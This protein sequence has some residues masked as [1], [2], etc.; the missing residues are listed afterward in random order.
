M[1][2]SFEMATKV[3]GDLLDQGVYFSA[4]MVAMSRA[5]NGFEFLVNLRLIEDLLSAGDISLDP[6]H[7]DH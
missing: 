2:K 7:G 6:N 1:D 3:C 5:N 4:I